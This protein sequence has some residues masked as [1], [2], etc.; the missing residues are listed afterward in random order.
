MEW[1]SI[2]NFILTINLL[3]VDSTTLYHIYPKYWNIL[4]DC[5]EVQPRQ[6]IGVMS[7]ADS[8]PNHTFT[9]QA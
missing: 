2:P 6:S 1:G 8:L 5:V 7:S 4:F 3:D 9:G